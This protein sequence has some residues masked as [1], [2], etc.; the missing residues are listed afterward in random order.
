[1]NY[2][3]KDLACGRWCAMDVCEQLANVGSEVERAI[4]WKNKNPDYSRNAIERALEL[5]ELTID[6]I[7]NKKFSRL[8]E[9][10][11]LKEALLDFFYCDN[12]FL[13]SDALFRK[14]FYAFA[15]ASRRK[16]QHSNLGLAQK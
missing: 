5:L 1:M 8:K 6:D 4:K 2:R 14:Y 15:W 9:L 16:R 3:H 10:S 13:S 11:R 7:K 12:Q